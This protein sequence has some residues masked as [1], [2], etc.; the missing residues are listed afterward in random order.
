MQ[1][2]LLVGLASAGVAVVAVLANALTT[3][4]S[5][6]VQRE[7]TKSTLDTQRMLAEAQES[8]LRE[9]SHGQELREQRAPLY[10]AL[11]RWS[12][13][14]VDVLSSMDSTHS[15]LPKSTWHIDPAVEDSLDLYAS[16]AVHIRFNAVR[17]ML[18][19]MVKDSGSE[20]SPIVRWEE[21]DGRIIDVSVTRSVPLRNWSTRARMRDDAHEAALYLVAA[22]RAEVQGAGHSGYFITYRL[23]RD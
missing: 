23:D 5:L 15:Q 4:Q 19:G 18:I 14:L 17:G 7:N 3:I 2:E 22:I 12:E 21:Q 11:L 16:D 20:D 9:R 1:S 6:K 13:D 8:G 10:K